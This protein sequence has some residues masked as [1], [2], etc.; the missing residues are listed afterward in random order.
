MTCRSRT[1]RTNEQTNKSSLRLGLSLPHGI[2]AC[3]SGLGLEWEEGKR[4]LMVKG[5]STDFSCDVHS[6]PLLKSNLLFFWNTKVFSSKKEKGAVPKMLFPYPTEKA[7]RFVVAFIP[8]WIMKFDS[9]WMLLV[10][11]NQLLEWSWCHFWYSV[12]I[13]YMNI[14]Y[15]Y[16]YTYIY[17]HIHT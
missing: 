14:Q 8:A 13:Q 12:C 3:V 4:V 6:A 16:M 17:I 5:F 9:G 10:T 7:D 1:K 11:T 15:T 2:V